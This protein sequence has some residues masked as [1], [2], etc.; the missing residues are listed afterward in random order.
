MMKIPRDEYITNKLAIP[1]L[2]FPFFRKG[3]DSTCYDHGSHAQLCVGISTDAL[4]PM[5]S[6][7]RQRLVVVCTDEVNN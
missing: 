5:A 3:R 6:S 4:L 1:F 7:W 2:C